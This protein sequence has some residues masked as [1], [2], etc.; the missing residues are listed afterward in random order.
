MTV[1]GIVTSQLRPDDDSKP[2]NN[3]R[4]ARIPE[5]II[6]EFIKDRNFNEKE[7]N[8]WIEYFEKETGAKIIRQ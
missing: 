5:Y 3:L 8:D 1:C 2:P 7:K 6:D 4:G